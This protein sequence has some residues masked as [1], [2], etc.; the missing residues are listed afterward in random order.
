MTQ[1]AVALV[2]TRPIAK[3][4]SR[5]AEL[6]APTTA[7]AATRA[8]ARDSYAVTAIADITDRSL[9]AAIAR[10]TAG[11]YLTKRWM[12]GA[13]GYVYQQLSCGSGSGDLL[14]QRR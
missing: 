11:F 1:S 10:F 3:A 13:V 2:S 4:S 5:I 14:R 12:V 8:D 9:H 6:A 7:G